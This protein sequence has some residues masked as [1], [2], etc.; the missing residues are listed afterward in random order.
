[1][2]QQVG[3]VEKCSP[4]PGAGG[5]SLSHPDSLQSSSGW[6]PPP[7]LPTIDLQ[8]FVILC[9]MLYIVIYGLPCISEYKD[10]IGIPTVCVI[11]LLRWSKHILS[12]I[13]VI[14]RCE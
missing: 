8:E 9:C 13:S 7:F 12:S 11:S 2:N 10:H 5:L 3:Q 4:G 1:M 6:N 14:Y